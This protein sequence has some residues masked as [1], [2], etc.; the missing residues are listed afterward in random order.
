MELDSDLPDWVAN[1]QMECLED[2]ID[3]RINW[4]C[5]KMVAAGLLEIGIDEHT[6]LGVFWPTDRGKVV[7]G[8]S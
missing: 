2:S 7:L 3:Q 6:G 8:M 1:R 4:E 5:W